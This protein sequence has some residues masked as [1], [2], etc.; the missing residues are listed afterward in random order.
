M[1]FNQAMRVAVLNKNG[2]KCY[3]CNEPI[4]IRLPKTAPKAYQ[5]E[6]IVPKAMGGSDALDNLM[7]SH[8]VCNNK[9]SDLPVSVAM[10]NLVGE[11]WKTSRN[12]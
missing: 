2:G 8:A 4:D 6:H 3:L 5:I 7:P 11:K 12:W 1:A 10:R 9:K